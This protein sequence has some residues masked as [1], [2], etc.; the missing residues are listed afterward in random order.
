MCERQKLYVDEVIERIS[1]P[2]K[3]CNPEG[4]P[5]NACVLP[6]KGCGAENPADEGG[7]LFLH[8][9]TIAYEVEKS[10]RLSFVI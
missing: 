9:K 4:P 5:C 2:G 6:T 3:Y 7:P 1:P 10:V 8:V